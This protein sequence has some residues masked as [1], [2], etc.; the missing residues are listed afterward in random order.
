MTDITGLW[1][2][3]ASGSAGTLY[4]ASIDV[5]GN[6]TGKI[7][8]V[9]APRVDTLM[10]A[11]WNDATATISF[12]RWI[13]SSFKQF[14]TGYLGDNHPDQLLILAGFFTDNSGNEPRDHIGWFAQQTQ[15][16][17]QPSVSIIATDDSSSP[18]SDIIV[19]LSTQNVSRMYAMQTT[20]LDPD[21][22]TITWTAIPQLPNS[23]DVAFM[24]SP[25]GQP[26]VTFEFHMEGPG[27]GGDHT[28]NL[29]VQVVD[30]LGVSQSDTEQQAIQQTSRQ[31]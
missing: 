16:R 4:V 29:T 18:P 19:P 9:D 24:T 10:N 21:H 2:V 12:E 27:D 15:P 28:F 6:L 1:Q 23:P 7:T 5:Q 31:F 20:H 3:N 22:P 26:T 30:K 17:P 13:G 11:T 14:F 25:Q 8:F